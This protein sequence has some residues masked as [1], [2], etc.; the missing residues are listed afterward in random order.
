MLLGLSPLTN[1]MAHYTHLLKHIRR[2]I[3][4]LTLSVPMQSNRT[5]FFFFFRLLWGL[6]PIPY[7]EHSRPFQ[8]L[9]C[10]HLEW[11]LI[12]L[13]FLSSLFHSATVSW[14][15]EASSHKVIDLLFLFIFTFRHFLA[16]R[17]NDLIS[18]SFKTG[19]YSLFC[20]DFYVFCLLLL[21][22][23]NFEHL[24]FI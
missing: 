7:F 14:E 18:Y 9:S 21:P 20:F 5:C 12:V 2:N 8:Y 17:R 10:L 4:I 16:Q 11:K 6:Q 22:W 15:F 23:A 24:E 13:K 3:L 1:L 19:F